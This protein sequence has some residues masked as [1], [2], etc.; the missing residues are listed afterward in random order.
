VLIVG[1]G[2]LVMKVLTESE[3]VQI[4]D[5][6]ESASGNRKYVG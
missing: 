2:G 3:D 6:F 1:L 4:K 5:D